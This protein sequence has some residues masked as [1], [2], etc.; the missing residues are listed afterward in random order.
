MI[1]THRQKCANRATTVRREKAEIWLWNVGI[2]SGL[3]GQKSR[4]NVDFIFS[5]VVADHI[6]SSPVVQNIRGAPV[7]HENRA[8]S[9]P[10][11]EGE[12]LKAAVESIRV[13]CQRLHTSR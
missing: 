12:Y 13:C 5:D 6:I 9:T 7:G 2:P 1:Y 11:K 8:H 4:T 3:T 10:L